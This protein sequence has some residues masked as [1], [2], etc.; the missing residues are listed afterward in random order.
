M[1]PFWWLLLVAGGV[2][3]VNEVTSRASKASGA[4]ATGSLGC[5]GKKDE[6][7]C[8]K[9]AQKWGPVFG[10]PVKTLMTIARIESAYRPNC[11]NVNLRAMALGGAWGFCQMTF[12]TAKGHAAALAKSTNK[13]VLATLARAWKGTPTS[14]LD[15]DL[16][17]MFACRQL[18][19]AT[20]EFGDDI[21]LV[22]GAYHQGAGKIRSMIKAGKSIP[23]ELP[24]F[25]KIYVASA[26]KW[27]PTAQG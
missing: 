21:K 22:A 12:T 5:K 19:N 24:P 1:H 11:V 26:L 4:G 2:Y 15:P 9:L 10:C 17:V 7:L 13:D 6:P 23:A 3:A 18:G 8:L 25:G 27:Y 20:K 14:L 16:N